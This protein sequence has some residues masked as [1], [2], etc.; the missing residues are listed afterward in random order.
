MRRL[1]RIETGIVTFISEYQELEEYKEG[2]NV[3]RVSTDL[4]IRLKSLLNL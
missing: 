1:K 4:G 2:V 3:C